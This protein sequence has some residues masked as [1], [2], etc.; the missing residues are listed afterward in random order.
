M[1][2]CYILVQGCVK[3]LIQLCT[4][5]VQL[6]VRTFLGN[7]HVRH[8]APGPDFGHSDVKTSVNACF[9]FHVYN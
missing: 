7:V 1:M 4:D 8:V 2:C 6:K 5:V 9:F 3:R